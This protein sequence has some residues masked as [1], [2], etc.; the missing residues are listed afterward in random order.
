MLRLRDISMRN[1]QRVKSAAVEFPRSGF[2]L[3][4]GRNLTSPG[5]FEAIGVGKTSLGEALAR[6]LFGVAGRYANL[7]WYSTDEAGNTYVRVSA[8]LSGKPLDVE[9]G[10]KCA[11]L[12]P[13]GEGLR[14]R[15]DGRP[16]SRPH[17]DETRNA[18]SALVGV[19]SELAEWSV[20]LDGDK[21]KFNRLSQAKS[22]ELLMQALAQPNWDGCRARA[23]ER[24][25]Q[26]GESLERAREKLAGARSERDR[27][28]A[29]I[30]EASAA[31][32]AAEERDAQA[33][34]NRDQK[35]LRARQRATSAQKELTDTETALKASRKKIEA[36]VAE[37]DTEYRRAE[38]RASQIASQLSTARSYLDGWKEETAR[39]RP[40]L[41][42]ATDL[43][44]DLE[45]A[46][47]GMCPR[48]GQPLP[49]RPQRSEVASAKASAA[50]LH[51]DL[52]AAEAQ[53]EL[54]RKDVD[55]LTDIHDVARAKAR[56]SPAAAAGALS[57]EHERLERE[58]EVAKQRTDD[59]Q[60]ELNDV[61]ATPLAP[62][63]PAAK[64]VLEERQD[65]Q[66]QAERDMESLAKELSALEDESAYDAYWVKAFSP[67]GI[68]NLVLRRTVGPLNEAARLT[69]LTMTGGALEVSFSAT[70]ELASG[71]EKPQLVTRVNNRFGASRFQG[72]SKGEAGLAN[73]ILAETQTTVGRMSRRVGWRWFDEVINTQDP[74]V[75][76]NV[77]AYLR[78]QAESE[79]LL[80]FVVDHHPEAASYAHHVLVA[81]KS[82]SGDTTYRWE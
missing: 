10:Y 4:R 23:A 62:E 24:L 20:F 19:S 29:R 51:V 13:T 78:Q 75:R 25:E 68:P 80:T 59:M 39:L 54:A 53:E 77:Y 58:L 71:E 52:A 27:L 74:Q 5:K 37:A 33:K 46:F 6:A 35:I 22:V 36:A 21:L 57:V 31:L 76:R 44:D 70:T 50:K 15:Y 66:R 60:S 34:A 55:R 67:T 11:E 3:V 82:A 81:E 61:L 72:N 26:H 73:L 64:A 56:R 43:R 16:T 47:N 18:L 69:S 1:W 42:E 14:F 32:R 17:P 65:A 7:G 2:V 49:N 12:S 40:L 38:H 48:C 63:S 30:S 28:V 9:M 8:D 45:T 79:D 41:K